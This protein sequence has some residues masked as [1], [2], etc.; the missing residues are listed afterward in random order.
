MKN[1][2]LSTIAGLSGSMALM[3]SGQVAHA[4][5]EDIIVESVTVQGNAVSVNLGSSAE[6]SAIS[7]FLLDAPDRIA[8]DIMD[9]KVA[10]DWKAHSIV[11]GELV[12]DVQ[13]TQ[14][15]DQ[16]GKIVRV[17]IF[18]KSPMDHTLQ[19]VGD[20]VSI[21]LTNASESSQ[22]HW[23]EH[24]AQMTVPPTHWQPNL[25][26][27]G[28]SD[29]L[30]AELE[31]AGENES[32][33]EQ[34]SLSAALESDAFASSLTDASD[35][36][37][38]ASKLSGP[39][40]LPT[41]TT[42]TSLDFEQLDTESRIIIGVKDLQNYDVNRPRP[43]SL[44]IDVEGASLPKSLSRI[45]D[46][47]HFYSPVQMVRA[48]RTSGGARISVSLTDDAEYNVSKAPNGYLIISVPIPASMRQ[49]QMASYQAESSVAPGTPDSGISNAYQKEIPNRR[50]WWY[51]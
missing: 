32:T 15:N 36:F 9:A 37:V 33:N 21:A 29:P 28:T 5:S 12:S 45:L 44:M 16:N 42:L 7:S 13:F 18:T 22:T 19:T 3:L 35:T 17:E 48:Y 23:R 38:P 8:I 50:V 40:Q 46:T 51:I 49:Q 1:R 11:A 2:S 20:V 34:D 27:E 24:L 31:S 26:I 43:D 39:D 30:M 25:R 4:Q 10:E 47:K 6:G 14:F 41:G